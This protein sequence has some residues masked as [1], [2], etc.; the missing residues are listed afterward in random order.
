MYLRALAAARAG[1]FQ[2]AITFAREL[3]RDPD[4][5]SDAELLLVH[6]LLETG[7]IA[8]ARRAVEL[9][10]R[11]RPDSTNLLL[12]RARVA[13]HE[14]KM[15]EQLAA[16]ERA[17]G[18]DPDNLSV[19][20]W[21]GIALVSAG[22]R[23]E[24]QRELARVVAQEP[25]NPIATRALISS[26]VPSRRARRG[27]LAVYFLTPALAVLA[28]CLVASL[29][30]GDT[31]PWLPS[32]YFGTM[33]VVI[34]GIRTFDRV[35]TDRHVAA[36]KRD[37]HRRS[38][39]G[40]ALFPTLRPVRWLL[41]AILAGLWAALA[42]AVAAFDPAAPLRSR[43]LDLAVS[44][45]G[46]LGL[47]LALW[48]WKR[49]RAQLA[50][51]EPRAFDPSSCHCHR[52]AVVGGSRAKAYVRRHL[53]LDGSALAAG[54]QPCRCDLLG[55]RWLWFSEE[56]GLPGME[57]AVLRLPDDFSAPTYL[58]ADDQRIGFYL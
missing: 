44:V 52:V 41:V 34:I 9:A 42:T 21:H 47:V 43:V 4:R 18:L 1:R 25:G 53:E 30:G 33:V 14:G 24:G 6:L 46:W 49:R 16:L 15:D 45:P 19:R 2:D 32:L 55:V 22:E 40:E 56:G 8:E 29:R 39:A 3:T 36:I 31:P 51:G 35:R 17:R 20:T 5:G 11:A 7:D 26:P 28:A 37:A 58:G 27:L 13:E 54:I 10:L 48:R 12:A 38:A 23:A 57:S 50:R